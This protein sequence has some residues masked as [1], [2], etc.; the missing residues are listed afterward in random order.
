MPATSSDDHQPSGREVEVWFVACD[1]STEASGE[2]IVCDGTLKVGGG[3]M[4]LLR[5]GEGFPSVRDL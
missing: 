4:T 5:D 2:A 3:D 1:A